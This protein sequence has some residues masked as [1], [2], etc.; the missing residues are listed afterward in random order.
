VGAAEDEDAGEDEDVGEGED[1]AMDE[2][3]AF[4]ELEAEKG[5]MGGGTR[6]G[7]SAVWFAH[8]STP[9]WCFWYMW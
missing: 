5:D 8:S 9:R 3:E 1:D 4:L 2:D 6:C 7:R